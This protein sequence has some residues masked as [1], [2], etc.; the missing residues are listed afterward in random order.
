MERGNERPI[1]SLKFLT[2]PL[3]GNIYPITKAV[4]SLGRGMAN[5]IVILD[6]SVSRHHAQIIWKNDTWTIKKLAT[7]NSLTVNQYEL[8]LSSLNNWDTIS[9]GSGTTFIFL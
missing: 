9:L 2:G 3:A 7:D 6:P 5:D 1:G 8:S 4:T